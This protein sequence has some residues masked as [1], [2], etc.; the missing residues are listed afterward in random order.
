[1]WNRPGPGG[2]LKEVTV[3]QAQEML[4]KG[5]AVL[6]DVR[7]PYEF[8][9]IHAQNATLIPLSAFGQRYK[10]IPQDK[11]VLLICRT[12]AR[13]AQAGMFTMQNGYS[14]VYNVRGGT[15][16]W[17]QAKLPTEKGM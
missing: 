7:E 9:E 4:D 2:G 16:A 3:Q 15:L 12:G 13:S 6:I 14:Q 10:E 11:E 5:G 8:K 17:V 1:M